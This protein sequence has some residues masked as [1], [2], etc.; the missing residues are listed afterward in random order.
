M[1]LKQ[2]DPLLADSSPTAFKKSH[3]VRRINNLPMLIGIGLFV[4]MLTVI[5]FSFSGKRTK[6]ATL[7]PSVATN[8]ESTHAAAQEIAGNILSGT[9][10]VEASDRLPDNSMVTSAVQTTAGTPAQP[11]R[12]QSEDQPNPLKISEPSPSLDTVVTSRE[13]ERQIR[14][15]FERQLQ[16]IQS[17][18]RVQLQHVS[19]SLIKQDSISNTSDRAIDE[20]QGQIE[21]LKARAEALRSERT[22]LNV[23][24]SSA[25]S[26]NQHNRW[27][28]NSTLKTPETQYELQT[29]AIIPG[30]MISGIHSQL[31]G[32][33]M[34]QVSQNVYDS[35]T[36]KYLL[37]PQGARLFGAYAN[38]IAY[39]Q[40]RVLIVWNRILFP[41]GK[42]LEIGDMAGADMAG[43]AGFADKVNHHYTRLFGSAILMSAITAGIS[44]SVD[45]YGQ[46]NND[47]DET[48]LQGAM[49]QSLGQQLGEVTSE[50]IRKNMNIAP[51]IEIRP[52]YQ[53]N[54][55][56][57]K[58]LVF[59]A[60]YRA[61][62]Y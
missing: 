24:Q 59:A 10:P 47:G 22:P 26:V 8:R 9:I 4:I 58:D 5:L 3:G 14:L 30:V 50:L 52:G 2:Q 35:A 19:H 13:V 40:S 39:G 57:T 1:K 6:E 42:S 32:S 31:P 41:D 12:K 36:G 20:R 38:Q 7:L 45:K 53:F 46:A 48:S 25:Y 33:I 29:G 18:S 27:R 37:L 15:Q 51:T 61:F 55:I 62:D 56:V 54:V 34:A 49:A 60:P 16:A 17:N 28:L 11:H 43:Y 23:A 21:Q 44:Y